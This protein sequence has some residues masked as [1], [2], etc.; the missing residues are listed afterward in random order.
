VIR[1]RSA[2]VVGEFLKSRGDRCTSRDLL[3]ARSLQHR[4]PDCATSWRG[5]RRA[6]AWTDRER[7]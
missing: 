1:N 6:R 2:R 3:R 4:W 5:R 7:I